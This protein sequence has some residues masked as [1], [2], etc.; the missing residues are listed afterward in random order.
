MEPSSNAEYSKQEY[1]DRRYTEEEHYDWFPSVYAA[2]VAA[3]FDAVEAVYRAQ[4]DSA[5]FNG[6]LK[7][8]HLGTGNSTLCADLRA[9]YE[10]RYAAVDARPYRLVQ[11]ATDYST[12]VIDHM[13]AK[14][15]PAHPLTD[16]HWEVADIRDLADVRE[17]HGPSFDV[18][19]DKG[20]MDAL[21][22]DKENSDMEVD[23]ER[24]LREVSRCVEG[25][26]VGAP[27]HRVFVQITWEIP[28]F[29]LYYTT[30]STTQTYAWGSN[31]TYRFLGDSD[32]Y[33]V[34]TYAVASSSCEPP[35]D[36]AAARS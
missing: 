20:T 19:L 5:A 3:C 12:V 8:L 34:Y 36:A 17:R 24:M 25:A 26:A 22:A 29:R 4:R 30:K 15:G 13:R 33:R 14:Y 23:I 21:Q 35:R 11:V 1:W 6:T 10:A 16:V 2:S 27:V 9:A 18:V 7:V 31:V 28:H 32:M